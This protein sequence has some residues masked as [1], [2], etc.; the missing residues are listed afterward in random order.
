MLFAR[1]S[2]LNRDAS[3]SVRDAFVCACSVSVSADRI[4]CA[5]DSSLFGWAQN[6]SSSPTISRT[7][8]RSV[9][10]IGLPA[11]MYSNNFSGDMK[12]A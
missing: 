4:S 2:Q 10:T 3:T 12:C 11:A 1:L 6:I 8:G 9:A 5:S 7:D